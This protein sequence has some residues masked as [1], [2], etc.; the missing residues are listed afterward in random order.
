MARAFATWIARHPDDGRFILNNGYD[1]SY[2]RVEDAPFQVVSLVFSGD[3]AASDAVDLELSDGTREPLQ[4][5]RL[6]LGEQGA[7]Y[8]TVKHGAFEAR[9]S[10]GAQL[11]LAPLLREDDAGAIWLEFAGQRVR[12]PVSPRK[13]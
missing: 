6:Y 4:P 13:A 3:G 7:L 10:R 9:F 11:S 2:F 8:A 12:L 5:E 1:W